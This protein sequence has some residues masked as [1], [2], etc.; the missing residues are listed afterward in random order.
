MINY[1]QPGTASPVVRTYPSP[2]GQSITANPD[3]LLVA[4]G[5]DDNANGWT[6]EGFDGVDNNGDGNVDELAE[7]EP[8]AW[9]GALA[10]GVTGAA[11]S[12]ARRPGPATNAR[13]LALPSNI[14]ID[15]KRSKIPASQNNLDILVRPDGSMAPSLPYATDASL[16]FGAGWWQL[17]LS[18]RS[19]VGQVAHHGSMVARECRGQ[20]GPGVDARAAGPH[21]GLCSGP[22]GRAMTMPKREKADDSR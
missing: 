3:Y 20:D 10:G 4:N 11:Y 16:T 2:D 21:G 5:L 18:R 15:L 6:D 1:G 22:S 8:E 19:D 7:W 14:V 12:L 9:R 17:W 13:E